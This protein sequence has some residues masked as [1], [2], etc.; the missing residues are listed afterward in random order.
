MKGHDKIVKRSNVEFRNLKEDVSRPTDNVARCFIKLF[1]IDDNSCQEEMNTISKM[2]YEANIIISEPLQIGISMTH[3][4]VSLNTVMRNFGIQHSPD[5]KVVKNKMTKLCKK[6]HCYS[7]CHLIGH[8]RGFKEFEVFESH[9]EYKFSH[10][11]D[12]SWQEL[13]EFGEQWNLIAS[14]R[15][16]WQLTQ[17]SGCDCSFAPTDTFMIVVSCFRQLGADSR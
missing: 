3:A 9:V 10:L 13:D 14:S 2:N 15:S 5:A 17:I 1:N 16:Q 4:G 8:G 12:R 7:H 11:L 6:C